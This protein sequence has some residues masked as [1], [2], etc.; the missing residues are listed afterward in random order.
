[1]LKIEGDNP[2]III[3]SFNINEYSFYFNTFVPDTYLSLNTTGLCYDFNAAS[4]KIP[5]LFEDSMLASDTINVINVSNSLLNVRVNGDYLSVKS[6]EMFETIEVSLELGLFVENENVSFSFM[7]QFEY[8]KCK[9]DVVSSTTTTTTSSLAS[10]SKSSTI[11]LNTFQ[12]L[13]TTVAPDGN[14]LSGG[15]IAG[16]VIGS[17]V[18]FICI[19][20]IIFMIKKKI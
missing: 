18:G 5:L 7:N 12:P 6:T 11:A 3:T 1:M 14:S 10:S 17:V 20:T 4:N 13:I 15:A 19:I 8:I 2:I 9:Q 16:I